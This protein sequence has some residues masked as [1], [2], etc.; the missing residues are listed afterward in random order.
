MALENASMSE[1]SLSETR[2]SE[3]RSSETPKYSMR[4]ATPED[5]AFLFKLYAS[6]RAEELELAGF[7][8]EQRESF[9]EMQF[10]ARQAH[11][12]N[13]FGHADDAIILLDGEPI[14]RELITRDPDG[15]SLTDIALLP[16]YC[17]RG[18]GTQRL[19]ALIREGAAKQLPL[20]LFVDQNSRAEQL[21][22]RHGFESVED[23]FPHRY[24]RLRPLAMNAAC[25]SEVG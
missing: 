9:C 24:M 22:F 15:I 6:T 20:F 10:K 23:H 14:G 11:Y 17:G 8:V 12:Q 18:I 25:V 2:L 5:E 19:L 13:H 4:G 16:E 1:T 21:Y 7:P 3:T